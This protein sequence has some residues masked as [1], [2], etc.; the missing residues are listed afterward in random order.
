M[1]CQVTCHGQ[2]SHNQVGKRQRPGPI[3]SIALGDNSRSPSVPI[4]PDPCNP[5]FQ[6]SN[7]RQISPV[8]TYPE[9]KSTIPN[10][11]ALTPALPRET[12][13]RTP[14]L[15]QVSQPRNPALT[16]ETQP[17]T[18]ALIQET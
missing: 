16:Q 9:S 4:D 18:P 7:M 5:K 8:P 10:I 2:S 13:P 17:R 1:P 3:R 12:Q 14:A 6:P 15:I 11:E